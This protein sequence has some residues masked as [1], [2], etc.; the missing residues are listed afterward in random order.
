MAR[1]ELGGTRSG[2]ALTPPH[3]GSDKHCDPVNENLWEVDVA[4]SLHVGS[5]EK[6]SQKGHPWFWVVKE[7]SLPRQ[8]EEKLGRQDVCREHAE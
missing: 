8:E 3:P 6:G 4:N 5:R 2:T 7:A 1:Q